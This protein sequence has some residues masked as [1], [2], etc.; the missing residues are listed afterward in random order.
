MS[1][2]PKTLLSKISKEHRFDN[3]HNQIMLIIQKSVPWEQHHQLAFVTI[4]LYVIHNCLS[5]AANKQGTEFL[6]V[7][8]CHRLPYKNYFSYISF[9]STVCITIAI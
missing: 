8:S 2:E 3:N 1:T 5:F 9:S 7:R 4:V 6:T